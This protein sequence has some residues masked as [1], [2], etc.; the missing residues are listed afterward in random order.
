[1]KTIEIDDD[2]YSALAHHVQGFNE[3]PNDVIGRLIQQTGIEKVTSE[4]KPQERA[5]GETKTE[6]EGLIESAEFRRL[7][8]D[9]TL[10]RDLGKPLSPI[11]SHVRKVRGVSTQRWAESQ[12]LQTDGGD[13]EKREQHRS[14]EDSSYTILR[15]H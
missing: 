15:P 3:S 9:W 2:V 7:R 6:L 4:A 14:T 10:P 8:C 12:L 5:S 1:M 11:S 13:R